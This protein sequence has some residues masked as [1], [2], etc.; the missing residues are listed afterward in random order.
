MRKSQK[1]TKGTCRKRGSECNEKG[2]VKKSNSGKKSKDR[3]VQ[4]RRTGN[5]GLT[6]KEAIKKAKEILDPMRVKEPVA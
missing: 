5:Q 1:K 2:W 6:W 3:V 4:L